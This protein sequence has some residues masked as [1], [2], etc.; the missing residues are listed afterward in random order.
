MPVP[1]EARKGIECPKLESQTVAILP[2]WKF[3][4]EPWSSATAASTLHYGVITPA[5]D[6]VLI[7]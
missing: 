1:K 7:T 6:M 2:I 3:G 5:L 4:T